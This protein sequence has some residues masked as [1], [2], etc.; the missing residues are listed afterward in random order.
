M[1]RILINILDASMAHTVWVKSGVICI[2]WEFYTHLVSTPKFR[3]SYSSSPRNH[4]FLKS[5]I[6]KFKSVVYSQI[7]PYLR[8]TW[9]NKSRVLKVLCA[10]C[11]SA[12]GDYALGPVHRMSYLLLCSQ[13]Y[14]GTFYF[15]TK[16]CFISIII[17]RRA[18]G[19][20]ALYGLISRVVWVRSGLKCL[21][22]N[23]NII[24]RSRSILVVSKKKKRE[25]PIPLFCN[26]SGLWNNVDRAELK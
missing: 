2:I 3:E 15:E 5:G 26:R 11:Q 23:I 20:T 25:G 6:Q 17:E 7:F 10:D 12:I 19:A 1:I 18:G 22:F 13:I 8:N 21:H 24:V 4:N 9:K 14:F 16:C